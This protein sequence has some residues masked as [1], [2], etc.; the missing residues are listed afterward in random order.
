MP[1]RPTAFVVACLAASA[2]GPVGMAH[3]HPTTRFKACA[4]NEISQSCSDNN[5]FLY[6]STVYLKGTVR[7]THAGQTASVLRRMPYSSVWRRVATVRISDS[8]KMRY[9]WVTTYDDA[10]QRRPYWFRFNIPGH[11]TSNDVQAWVISGE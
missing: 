8:G 11:G 1:R 6:G 7:P 10:V 4:Y 3:A 2:L 5:T 9:S